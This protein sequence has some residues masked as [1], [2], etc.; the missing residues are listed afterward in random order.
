[1]K[2]LKRKIGELI[3]EF[4]QFDSAYITP[5][6]KLILDAAIIYFVIKNIDKVL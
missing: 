4:G 5:I 2:A 3:R 6:R 1:M